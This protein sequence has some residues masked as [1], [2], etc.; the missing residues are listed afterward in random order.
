MTLG[1]VAALTLMLSF[2]DSVKADYSDALYPPDIPEAQAEITLDLKPCPS[3]EEARSAYKRMAM[4]WHPDKNR[5]PTQS[6]IFTE[7]MAN[8]T[9]AYKVLRDWL[10]KNGHR[11]NHAREEAEETPQSEG[12]KEFADE[13]EQGGA[14]KASTR[15]EPEA[16]TQEAFEPYLVSTQ[17]LEQALRGVE[18]KI[19]CE[20]P[21]NPSLIPQWQAY[22]QN[23]FRERIN[24]LS[25]ILRFFH[26]KYGGHAFGQ[27][28]AHV[29]SLLW[30]GIYMLPFY[31]TLKG[32]GYQGSQADVEEFYLM[33]LVNNFP[34]KDNSNNGQLVL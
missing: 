14:T 15:E 23:S 33:N 5:D 3:F 25:E 10:R 20:V 6:A 32:M 34:Y 18:S 30:L 22:H 17:G 12:S 9:A 19:R 26:R 8:V 13:S 28:Y 24:E 7:R 2:F 16:K 29:Q 1:W 4:I 11:L 27:K 21:K 31:R